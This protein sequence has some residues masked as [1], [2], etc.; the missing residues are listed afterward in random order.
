VL[1][2]ESGVQVASIAHTWEHTLVSYNLSLTFPS[3]QVENK[4]KA[5]LIGAAFLLV[6]MILIY[7]RSV[8][9]TNP[10]PKSERSDGILIVPKLYSTDFH[11]YLYHLVLFELFTWYNLCLVRSL[12]RTI[13]TL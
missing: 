9:Q 3:H 5:L 10:C 11:P 12:K 4:Q 13:M 8:N 6:N 7:N 1:S 2:A